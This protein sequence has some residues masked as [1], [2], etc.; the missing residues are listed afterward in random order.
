MTLVSKE[1][2]DALDWQVPAITNL[3]NRG[4]GLMALD[5]EDHLVFLE[6]L[7]SQLKVRDE[8]LLGALTGLLEELRKQTLLLQGIGE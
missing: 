1:A 3:K 5:R 4:R 6:A 2:Q 7:G 8:A